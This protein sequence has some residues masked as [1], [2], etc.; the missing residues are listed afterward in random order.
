MDRRVS[1]F[2]FGC[3]CN[4]FLKNSGALACVFDLC[5]STGPLRAR[6]LPLATATRPVADHLPSSHRPQVCLSTR[7]PRSNAALLYAAPSSSLYRSRSTHSCS[8]FS[9][10]HSLRGLCALVVDLAPLARVLP[11]A[12]APLALVLA[13]ALARWPLRSCCRSRPTSLSP[14][15]LLFSPS[16]SLC[17]LCALAVAL[18][19]LALA[20]ARAL[21]RCPLLSR[22]LSH[23]LRLLS[24]PDR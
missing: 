14:H 5:F 21:A 2:F 7:P 15:S 24:L 19:P 9:L 16:L 8:L 20:L 1:D 3:V 13:L 11:I 23:S 6:S 4:A 22:L 18:A 12:L 17:G 10:S